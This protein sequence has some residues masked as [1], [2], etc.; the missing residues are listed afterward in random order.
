[1]QGEHWIMIAN[2]CHEL[3]F[4]GSLG[5]EKYSFLN[6]HYNHI[7]LEPLQSH[8]SICGFY[9]VYAAFHLFKNQPEVITGNRDFIELSFITTENLQLLGCKWA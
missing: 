1:M 5:R 8:P 2:S 3:Y 4:A 7:M 9:T 6:R